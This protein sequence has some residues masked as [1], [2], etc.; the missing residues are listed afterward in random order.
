MPIL[1]RTCGRNWEV[2]ARGCDASRFEKLK[3]LRAEFIKSGIIIDLGSGTGIVEVLLSDLFSAGGIPDGNY[4]VVGVDISRE[5]LETSKSRKSDYKNLETDFV[6]CDTTKSCIA[7][8]CADTV[9]CFSFLHE[10]YS[11]SGLGE[12]VNDLHDAYRMLKPGGR[13]II[14]DGVKPDNGNVYVEFGNG[15]TEKVFYRFA[16][17]FKPCKEP[18][19]KLRFEK[20]NGGKI[21]LSVADCFEF[22]TKY[23]YRENWDIEVKERFGV[24]TA[25]QWKELLKNMGFGILHQETHL[26]HYLKNRYVQDGIRLYKSKNKNKNADAM[27]CDGYASC[28]Y[29]DSTMILVAEK[30]R[31]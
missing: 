21:K 2:Y 7:G 19:Y 13:L 23:I 11:D 25:G 4:F 15:D 8:S 31:V 24:L 30:G 9:L 26:I 10:R 5:M 18:D 3:A 16:R 29:P 28:E 6:R 22:L 27:A 17:D 14:R 1:E 20:L 12:M